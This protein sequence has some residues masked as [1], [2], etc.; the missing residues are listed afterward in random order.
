MNEENRQFQI[1]L[2]KKKEEDEAM[3]NEMFSWHKTLK[4]EAFQSSITTLRDSHK[5]QLNELAS[6]HSTS[7]ANLQ[8][9]HLASFSEIESLCTLVQIARS[10]SNQMQQQYSRKLQQLQEET[11]P[12]FS[13]RD[14]SL[15]SFLFQAESYLAELDVKT[16]GHSGGKRISLLHALGNTIESATNLSPVSLH[17]G[18]QLTP[19]KTVMEG[20][21]T[22]RGKVHKN[23]KTRWFVLDDIGLYYYP[24]EVSIEHS[25]PFYR[26]HERLKSQKQ[27][28][29]ELSKGKHFSMQNKELTI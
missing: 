23:W 3:L 18:S 29:W 13:P 9:K 20:Y 25:K 11:N 7:L 15:S 12:V 19:R 16:A 5:E 6:Q 27:S 4:Q 26:A 8:K 28:C 21:L 24:S 1:D 22:K 2:Q 17:S 14:S 10:I